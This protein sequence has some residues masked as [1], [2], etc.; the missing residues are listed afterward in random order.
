MTRQARM[1]LFVF[2]TFGGCAS[3][4]W[5]AWHSMGP[6]WSAMVFGLLATII[7]L[8]GVGGMQHGPKR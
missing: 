8:A 4:L 7:G 5:G 3:A 2:M 1:S 6:Y